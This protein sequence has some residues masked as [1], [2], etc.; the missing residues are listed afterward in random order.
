[1]PISG[2]H[3]LVERF[4]PIAGCPTL[5]C[6]VSLSLDCSEPLAEPLCNM[7]LRAVFRDVFRKPSELFADI[8]S[9]EDFKGEIV[10]LADRSGSMDSK[11]RALR[12]VL[13]SS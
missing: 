3:I 2:L 13:R 9:V 8:V 1:M 11:I 10:F 5:P 4:A 7:F 6:F 12:D